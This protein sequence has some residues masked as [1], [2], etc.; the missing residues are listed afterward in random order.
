MRVRPLFALLCCAAVSQ[1]AFAQL[2]VREVKGGKDHPLLSRFEG[3][4]MV[5]YN[6]V[7]Y[8]QAE[9][10]ASRP[11]FRDNTIRVDNLLKPEGPLR[12]RSIPQLPGCDRAGRPE[13]DLLLRKKRSLRRTRV[14]LQLQLPDA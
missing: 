8:D 5:G 14:V 10:P 3:A 4:K 2:D 11:Y 7:R 13:G 6:A 12:T 1:S 9:L